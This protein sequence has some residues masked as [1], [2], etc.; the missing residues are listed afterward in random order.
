M[1]GNES[2]R[3]GLRGRKWLV[4]GGIAAVLVLAA[5]V[6]LVPR[7]LYSLSHQ[8][9]DDAFVDGTIVPVSAEV[10]GTVSRVLVS[11]HEHVTRGQPLVEI[12]PADY[13]NTVEERDARLAQARSEVDRIRAQT[14][15]SRKD[16]AAVRA[17][18]EA[19]RDQAA[20]AAKDESRYS[21]LVAQGAISESQYDQI[22]TRRKLADSQVKSAVADVEKAEADLK[23]LDAQESAQSSAVQAAQASLERARRDLGRT[24]ITSPLTGTVAQENVDPGRFVQVGQPLLAV[25]NDRDVWVTANFKETQIAS[26]RVGQ[27][28]EVDV[29]AYPGTRVRG[30]VR[31]FEPGTGAVFSLLPPENATGNFIKTV[32][33]VPVRISLEAV[34]DP[35]H[36]LFPGLS[37]TVHVAV[38]EALR[39]VP[40]DTTAV[41]AA[42]A[43]NA[44][45]D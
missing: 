10:S 5:A 39:A 25:V 17:R 21:D 1:S 43:R 33:R 15:E 44:R 22:Q 4:R 16:L 35:A 29:D 26:I 13:R 45:G 11:S 40:A 32:Q 12:T 27:P 38:K 24:V 34:S 18:L 41:P 42:S 20:L 30:V 31:S 2:S 3:T 28:V 8:S 19:A 23:S 37:A 6:F 9:T 36:P 14:D 7:L